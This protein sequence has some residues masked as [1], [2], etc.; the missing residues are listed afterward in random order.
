MTYCLHT[1]D[2]LKVIRNVAIVVTQA[3]KMLTQVVCAMLGISPKWNQ[4]TVH[5]EL[6]RW[7]GSFGISPLS[8]LCNT[9]TFLKWL[10]SIKENQKCLNCTLCYVAWCWANFLTWQHHWKLTWLHTTTEGPSSR[11]P[12]MCWPCS[13]ILMLS[14]WAHTS[15]MQWQQRIS[16]MMG[17]W[18]DSAR[19]LCEWTGYM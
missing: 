1:S 9:R 6:H 12:V 10:L 5:A 2:H 7:T 15:V 11:V 4:S 17:E 3:Q 14:R 8:F 18:A 19:P 13:W 16:T